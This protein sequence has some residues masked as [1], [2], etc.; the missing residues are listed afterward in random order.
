MTMSVTRGCV[1]VALTAVVASGCAR[2]TGQEVVRVDAR[3]E[4]P[5]VAIQ[6][7][8]QPL[9]FGAKRDGT[10]YIPRSAASRTPLPLIVLMHGGGQAKELFRFTFPLAEELGVVI[11]TLDSRD[12]TWDGVDSPFGPDVVFIDRALRHTFKRVAVDPRRLA[13]G[14]FSDG[15]SYALSLGLVNGDLFTHLVAFS[16]GFIASPA[17]P[18]GMPR[19]FISHGTRDNVLG[20]DLTSRR[21]VPRLKSRGYDVTYQEFDGPH[22]TPPPIARKA[23]QW[24]VGG[25]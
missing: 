5:A 17:P 7:G 2:R 13:L 20:I 19:I 9:G 18:A 21:L 10:L 3:P 1:A 14:G 8:E 24:L 11:L 12:N 22:N 16:P 15:A 23:L 25:V 6:A 4:A